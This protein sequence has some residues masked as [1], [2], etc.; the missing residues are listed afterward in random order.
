MREWLGP[1]DPTVRQL[2]G[3]E[4]P[5]QLAKRLIATTKLADPATRVAL[6]KGGAKAVDAANDPMIAIA[7][8]VDP[9]ARAIRKKYEDEI[10]AVTRVASEKV[11]KARFT[12]FGTSV[13][14]DAT[15]TLRLKPR[16]GAG[17]D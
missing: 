7:K 2:L 17:L 16:L 14:P 8:L 1:D 13:Y 12:A 3:K 9:R 5:D 10:K 15:F 11:A 6:W 4:S